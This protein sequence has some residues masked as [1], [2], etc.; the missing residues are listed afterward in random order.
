M[1]ETMVLV[2]R[3]LGITLAAAGL[4]LVWLSPHI[5]DKYGLTARKQIDPRLTGHMSAEEIEKFRR[6]S[7]VLDVKLRSLLVALPGLILI[8][9]AFR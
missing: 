7:A 4:I 3:I 5:V 1:N 6:E 2:L 9:V 8:L